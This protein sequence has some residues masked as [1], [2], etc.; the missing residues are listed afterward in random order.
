MRDWLSTLFPASYKGVPFEV[1]TDGEEGG[2]RIEVHEFPLR[3]D[4]FL[5]DLG[6]AARYFSVTAYLASDAA[7]AQAAGL[8]AAATSKGPGTLVLPAHGPIQARCQTFSRSREKD[9]AGYIAFEMKFVR[10]G[11]AFALS[12]VPFL[13]NAVFAAASALASVL[14]STARRNIAISGQPDHVIAPTIQRFQIGIARLGQIRGGVS[15]DPD[16]SVAAEREVNRLF[17]TMPSLLSPTDGFDP[18]LPGRIADLAVSLSDGMD[19]ASAERAFGDWLEAPLPA[20]DQIG[21]TASEFQAADNQRQTAVL[22]RLAALRA[23]CEALT[24]RAFPSR[25][26]AISARANAVEY[27]QAELDRTFGAEDAELAQALE[28]LRGTLLDYLTRAVIDLAPVVVVEASRKLPALAW[29]WALYQDPTRATELV[30]RN[31]A[32]MPTFMP[33]SFE[34]LAR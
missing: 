1:E 10:E 19:P 2:R 25:R 32:I 27:F 31:N 22:F 23:Y 33:L 34:A 20:I 14:S 24:R 5:E 17:A 3:D 4:P 30:S 21:L 8:T 12:S 28:T 6:E 15:L 11:A 7:D 16:I 18:D 9:K 13:A 26:E 29:A